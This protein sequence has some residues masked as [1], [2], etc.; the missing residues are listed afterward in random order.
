MPNQRLPRNEFMKEAAAHLYLCGERGVETVIFPHTNRI[1]TYMGR[2]VIF[3]RDEVVLFE[4]C[5]Y[6][7]GTQ[8][9]KGLYDI[10]ICASCGAEV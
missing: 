1:V 5:E 6:C 8:T 7:G 9:K 4:K 3:K 2:P 10:T